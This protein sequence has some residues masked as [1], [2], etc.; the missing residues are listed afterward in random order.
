VVGKSEN[1]RLFLRGLFSVIETAGIMDGI[2]LDRG[3]GF[4]AKISFTIC[5]RIGTALILGR[6]RYPPGHGK[7]ERFNQ[8]C[9]NDLLRGIAQDPLIDPDCRSLEHRINHY[10]TNMYNH[11]LHEGI[12]GLS[13]EVKWSADTRPLRIPSDMRLLESH[14]V[15]TSRRKVSRDN[16]VMVRGVGYEM[17]A[18]YDGR[19]VDVYD[20]TLEHRLTVIHEGKHVR[21]LPVDLAANARAERRRRVEKERPAGPGPIKTAAQLLYERDHKTIV[22]TG[23]DYYEM[24]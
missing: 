16:V 23:G 22:T 19:K 20:H 10:I 18:G 1:P 9:L 11:R 21:L 13:P 3:P 15:I 12:E 7:I 14:F 2:Y 5:A 17:P 6:A 8:T 24:D 4:K